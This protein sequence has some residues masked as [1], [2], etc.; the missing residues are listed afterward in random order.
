MFEIYQE[1]GLFIGADV[2][3]KFGLT[4]AILMKLAEKHLIVTVDFP[5][6]HRLETSG[7]DVANFNH[8]RPYAG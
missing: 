5:L 3:K 6:A 4:D 7:R 2:N 1:S 8:L